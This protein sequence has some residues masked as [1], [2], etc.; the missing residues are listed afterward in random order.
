MGLNIIWLP[1]YLSA[2]F[3]GN[4]EASRQT[5]PCNIFGVVYVEP[6]ERR[7]DYVVYEEKTEAFADL[8]VFK[9]ENKLLADDAGLWYFTDKRDLA[10]F[11]IYIANDPSNVHFTIYYT[12]VISH[13]GCD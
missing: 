6:N 10:D 4:E 13:A 3:F 7:A 9:E 11:S 5:D 8:N 1:V 2:F 12:D